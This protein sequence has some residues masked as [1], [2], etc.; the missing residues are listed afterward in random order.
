MK[1][2]CSFGIFLNSAHLICR[3]SDISKCVSGSL[4]LRDNESWLY[5]WVSFCIILQ[6]ALLHDTVEDT[7]TTFQ[8]I[9]DNFGEEVEGSLCSNFTWGDDVMWSTSGNRNKFWNHEIDFTEYVIYFFVNHLMWVGV[10]A[11]D[12]VLHY[13]FSDLEMLSMCVIIGTKHSK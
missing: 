6:A 12:I 8:E 13:Y 7:D 3:S 11:G 9:L 4:Q 5:F 2:G 10:G 1:F